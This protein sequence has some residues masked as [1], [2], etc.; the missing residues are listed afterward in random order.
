MKLPLSVAALAC[1]SLLATTADAATIFRQTFD[2]GLGANE[3]VGGAF[4]LTNSKMGHPGSLHRNNDYSYYQLALDLTD[5]RDATMTF[6]Y[7]IV[8]EWSYDGFNVLAS[9]DEVFDHRTDLL[10]PATA[11]F[12][13]AM[14]NSLSNLGKVAFSGDQRGSVLFDLSQ[15]AGQKVNLRFQFQADYAAPKRGVLLDNLLVAGS[16]IASAVPEPAT[17]AMM[18]TGFGLA[19]AALRQRRRQL[20]ALA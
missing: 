5:Y 6:D 11:G 4:T 16:P 18:I 20:A 7:D 3:K 19:G 12:Y 2:T 1:A 8:S 9:L 15:F 13:S 10:N 14:S 17:W